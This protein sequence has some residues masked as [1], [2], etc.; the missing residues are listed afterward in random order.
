MK[1][2]RL[3][4]LALILPGYSL[5]VVTSKSAVQ[6]SIPN[7]CIVDKQNS[8]SS[9]TATSLLALAPNAKAT[10]SRQGASYF[11]RNSPDK[12]PAFCLNRLHR[13]GIL[14]TATCLSNV[15]NGMAVSGGGGGDS[16]KSVPTKNSKV[17]PKMK[18]IGLL[19]LVIALGA[20]GINYRD[21]ISS[22]EFKKFLA[23][24]LD[25]LASLGTPGLIFYTFFFMLWEITF[26]MTTPVE[27]AAGMAFG[28]KNGII[29]NAIGKTS[30]ALCAFLLGRSVLSDYSTKK[31][32]G[33]EFMD[34][35]RDSIT[36]NPIRVALIWRFSFLPE[37]VKNFG[38]AVLPVKTWQFFTAVLLHGFPFTV[39]WTFMG[40]EM[41]E[42]IRGISEPT[43]TLKLLVGLVYVFGFFISPALVGL[44][45][46]S[47]RDEKMQRSAEQ[48]KE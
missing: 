2:M 1:L 17:T 46:K 21:V 6:Y 39:L 13:Q 15:R 38:L 25:A 36:K 28:L 33:N 37:F 31:L 34:L 26:G 14:K 4:P 10:T 23:L 12:F 19:S 22:F 7:Q 18:A 35:V 9:P 8:V 29:A 5:S 24:Q 44:W 43:R 47:L 3:K 48:K 32:E 27:T 42:V 30:G 20:L 40:N 16:N 11:Y 45:L 41:G